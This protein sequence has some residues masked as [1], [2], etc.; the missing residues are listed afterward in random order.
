MIS[1]YERPKKIKMLKPLLTKN[2]YFYRRSKL[3]FQ[4]L[5]HIFRFNNYIYGELIMHPQWSSSPKL[6]S[7]LMDTRLFERLPRFKHADIYVHS[8]K[9]EFTVSWIYDYKDGYLLPNE[10]F[11]HNPYLQIQNDAMVLIDFLIQR[12]QQLKKMI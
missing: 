1:Y 6:Q 5:V 8:S 2:N 4:F 10:D 12:A 11:I 9:E 3:D 7:I